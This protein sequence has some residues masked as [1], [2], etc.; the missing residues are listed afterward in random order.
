MSGE[1]IGL[2]EKTVVAYSELLFKRLS[3]KTEETRNTLIPMA[4]SLNLHL[5]NTK[6][7]C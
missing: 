3:L 4:G 5:L 6:Q 7:E 1:S 2:W